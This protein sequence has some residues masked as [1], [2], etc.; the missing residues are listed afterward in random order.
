VLRIALRALAAA[1]VLA[2]TAPQVA[3]AK[4]LPPV[5]SEAQTESQRFRAFLDQA[6]ERAVQRSPLLAADFGEPVGEDR[7]DDL[8]AA[9]VAAD[10]E[11][12]RK[13]LAAAKS[14]FTYDRLDNATKL[15]YRVFVNEAQLLLDRYHWRDKLYPLNQIVGL[16]VTVPD[17][18]IN[19]Q[20]L[21]SA[22]E[23]RT[24]IRRVSATRTL[25][26]Q[27]IA[28]MKAQ[29]GKGTYMPKSVYP[30]LIAGSRNV[31]TGAPFDNG[32]DSAIF[33]DF[34]RRTGLLNLPEKQKAVLVGECRSALLNDL[35]PAY[36]DLIALLEKQSAQTRIDGGVWQLP[37]GDELY[38]F[39]I[40]QFTTTDMTPAEVHELGLQQVAKVHA[41]IEAGLQKLGFNGTLREFMDRT[42]AEPRFYND[43]TD[44]GREAFL[45]RARQIVAAMQ[46]RIPEQFAGP[47]PLPLQIR[48]TEAYKEASAPSGFY[49][50]GSVDGK[51]P[52]TVYLNLSDMR[53]QPTYELEDLLYHE[54]LPGHHL[55]ISTILSDGGIP[56]LRKV[57][58][59]WQDTAFVE[60]WG[61]YG[62]QLGKDLGFY[63]DPY[64]DLGRLTGE[65]WRACRLVVDS[66]LHYKRWS[67][68]QAIAYLEENSAAPHGTIVREVDRYLVVPGQATAF[69]VGMLKFVAERERARTA[70]GPKFD[71][72]Q[73]HR[74]V[75]E[76]GYLPL[77]AVH[78]RVSEWIASGGSEFRGFLEDYWKDWLRL[79]PALALSVGDTSTEEQFDESLSDGWRSRALAM[80][81]RY[82]DALRRVDRAQ[83]GDEDRLSYDLLRYRLESD[84][85]FYSSRS[86]EIARFLPVNQFQGLHV[87]YAVEAAGSGAFPYKTVADYD[88]A[89]LRAAGFARWV[90]AAIERLRQGATQD[91]VLPALI[92]ERMLPQLRVHLNVPPEQ[93]QF[94]HPIQAMP[95]EFSAADK[96]RLSEAYRA[97]IAGVIQPA[98]QRLYDYLRQGYAPHARKSAGLG[99]IP[100]GKELYNY[101][102][103]YH[104]TTSLT[105]AQI[106]ELGLRQ[107]QEISA[108]LAAVQRTVGFK[109]TL[110][111]FFAHVRKDPQQHFATPNDVLP[112]FQAARQR[113]VGHLPELFDVLP[114][115]PYEVRALPDSYRQ[116]RDNGYYSAAA[117]DGSRPGILW[118]NV[119]APGVQDRFNLMTIS[120][121]EGLPGHHLQASIAQERRD[122]PAF[123]R[124]DSTTAYVEGW[125]LYAESLGQE[126]GFYSDPWQYYGHL[127]YAILRANRLVID[128]GIHEMGW[129]IE[130]GVRWMTGHSSMTAAQAAAEVERYAAYPG[131]ALSYKL[132]ELKLLELR[133][134]A[135]ERSGARFDIKAFHD[136]ILSGGSMPLEILQQ[137]M[138]RW[139]ASAPVS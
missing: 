129:S 32:A 104:T 94:W 20:P 1:A 77:W 123:R 78:D 76:N 51:R 55:Q 29:A 27:L 99:A 52:G 125:G 37:N 92:V 49:E 8:S 4:E 79:D 26:R 45:A 38:K 61:L 15:Q 97:K 23:A 67:R 87:Q 64:A 36:R 59:W 133:Q 62:E 41:E 56:K 43:N 73:Y 114:K 82:S 84:L 14:Q 63:Q 39:L 60:G 130:Q 110:P 7:W 89:L 121:H 111:Q 25:F 107:V 112:A 44:A 127:N 96:G 28:Q 48:R 98:Y 11:V 137:K 65:L 90:D 18:L 80:L 3:L 9:G 100:G 47:A 105:A 118:I 50:P 68:D 109:G 93:T 24:Y 134:K 5:S 102:V 139:L 46:V 35:G 117:A 128:T 10:N 124:F 91:V 70:L 86:F 53:L 34:K 54:G 42:R 22:G 101:Y 21:G 135:Q 136:Q 58:Q 108:Q 17:V 19:K 88:K 106:H 31:I 103:R 57:N 12:V 95:V 138:E 120:L 126:M 131:Q 122:L 116:S 72:R 81:H 75:L 2:T 113:I 119:Y 71:I 85:A 69:T 66:G 33:A 74:I 115:T 16:H 132:G 83:L 40:H 6:Y 30:L 13:Q